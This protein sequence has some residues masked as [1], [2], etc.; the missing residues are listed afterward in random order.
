MNETRIASELSRAEARHQER[1][2]AGADPLVAGWQ[3]FVEGILV[4]LADYLVPGRLVTFRSVTPDETV[5]FE[6]LSS[7]V[8]VPPAV[9]AVFIPPSVRQGMLFTSD[10]GPVPARIP[11]DS[12]IVLACRE[13]DYSIV[14]NTFFSGPPY[15]AGIDVYEDGRLLAGY[16]YAT[17][18]ECR[19]N[20]A[21]ILHTY[22]RPPD[23]AAG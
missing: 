11:R 5:F 18:D 4:R 22:L 23:P 15:A 16:S 2:Q 12:G 19:D 8:A 13:R 1:V 9:C 3:C 6:G 20:L 10:S 14:L 7:A 21:R 17:V